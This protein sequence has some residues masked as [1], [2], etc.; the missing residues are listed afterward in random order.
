MIVV[1]DIVGTAAVFLFVRVYW[2][3]FPIREVLTTTKKK[4]L[5]FQ[6]LEAA[7]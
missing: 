7:R 4:G 3:A 2:R 1:I 6:S 5:S